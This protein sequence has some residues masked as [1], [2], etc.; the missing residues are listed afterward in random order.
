MSNIL[1]LKNDLT[2]GALIQMHDGAAKGRLTATGFADNAQGLALFNLKGNS[3]HGMELPG[4][5][6]KVFL[7]VFY[8][9]NRAHNHPSFVS[10]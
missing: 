9:K 8:L 4:S 6:R 2:F 7:Q 1:T 5:H 3:I 10:L